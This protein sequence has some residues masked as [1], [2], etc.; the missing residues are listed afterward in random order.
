V[1][2]IK[3][4]NNEPNKRVFRRK[5]DKEQVGWNKLFRFYYLVEQNLEE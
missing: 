5:R 4:G 2:C 1:A 3:T